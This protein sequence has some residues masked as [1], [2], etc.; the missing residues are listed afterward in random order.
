MI[1]GHSILSISQTLIFAKD[2]SILNCQIIKDYPN[3]IKV[4]SKDDTTKTIQELSKS[5]IVK[6]QYRDGS[7]NILAA[8]NLSE[9]EW[10]IDTIHGNETLNYSIFYIVYNSGQSVDKPFPIY[11]NSKIGRAHV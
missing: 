7:A 9:L 5:D 2:R 6:I 8:S 4:I 3:K 1:F 10:A 11:F